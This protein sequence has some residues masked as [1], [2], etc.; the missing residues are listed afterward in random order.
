M[1][2]EK[3]YPQLPIKSIISKDSE[4]KAWKHGIGCMTTHDPRLGEPRVIVGNTW[5]PNGGEKA[6]PMKGACS[7]DAAGLDKFIVLL[8]HEA[9]ELRTMKVE[10]PQAASISP[11]TT[12]DIQKKVKTQVA[13]SLE[14]IGVEPKQAQA[15]AQEASQMPTAHAD[16]DVQI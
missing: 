15:L 7:L 3:I 2:K 4:G 9:E 10:P 16:D 13:A 6:T 14:V 8:Q 1:P 12:L 11:A 5:Y